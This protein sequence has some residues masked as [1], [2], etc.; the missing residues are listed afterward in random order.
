MKNKKGLLVITLAS[1]TLM[2]FTQ[3]YFKMVEQVPIE[4]ETKEI[5]LPKVSLSQTASNKVQEI[6]D[7][8]GKDGAF[9]II[10][11]FKPITTRIA[12]RYRDVPGYDEQL[13]I[14]EIETGRRGIYDM[15]A[16]EYDPTKNDSL[17]AYINTYLPSRAIEAANRILDTVPHGYK[18]MLLRI[19]V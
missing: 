13:L 17:A 19:K 4:I 12:R 10:E 6:Y 1:I 14:D 7:A 18:D 16:N 9:E 15:I 8:K 3:L 5:E 11:Q 2:S